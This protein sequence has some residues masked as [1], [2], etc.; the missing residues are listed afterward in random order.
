MKEQNVKRFAF[1]KSDG[2]Y[3]SIWRIWSNKNDIYVAARSIA[4]DIKISLHESGECHTAFTTQFMKLKESDHPVRAQIRGS[5]RKIRK[6]IRQPI[7]TGLFRLF[8]IIIPHERMK[9]VARP[10]ERRNEID[11]F[12]TNESFLNTH[13]VFYLSDIDFDLRSTEWINESCVMTNLLHKGKIQDG[14]TFYAV[15]FGTSQPVI[16]WNVRVEENNFEENAEYRLIRMGINPTSKVGYVI[17][18]SADKARE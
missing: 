15:Y 6:W 13:I 5:R 14:K 17:D 18:S 10:L 11:W 12:H 7:Q 9:Y 4:G 2:S 8:E 16:K 3:S 1:V